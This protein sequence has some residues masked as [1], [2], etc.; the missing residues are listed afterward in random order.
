MTLKRQSHEQQRTESLDTWFH[1]LAALYLLPLTDVEDVTFN[2]SRNLPLAERLNSVKLPPRPKLIPY[3]DELV[4][5][6]KSRGI[7]QWILI[8]FYLSIAALVHYGM[9]IRSSSYGL[10]DQ[11]ES[12]ITTGTW[13]Y[14]PSF[15]LK[16]KYIGIGSIDNYLTFLSAAYM[17][18]LNNWNKNFGMLQ[19]YFLGMLLQPIAIWAIEACRKR[20]SMTIV[21]A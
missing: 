15:P 10:A 19:M 9:W 18:G 1:K 17:P 3:K 8:A 16:R 20:N 13:T 7:Y 14:D 21:S 11:F 5:D 2:F 6:P 4:S 12:I